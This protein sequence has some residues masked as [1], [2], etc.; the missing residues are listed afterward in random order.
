MWAMLRTQ[1][2]A[3]LLGEYEGGG[4]HVW[5]GP[6]A[7]IDEAKKRGTMQRGEKRGAR[8]KSLAFIGPDCTEKPVTPA[9][10]QGTKPR[11]HIKKTKRVIPSREVKTPGKISPVSSDE[12]TY[13]RGGKGA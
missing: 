11:D 6:R 1:E 12:K 3:T 5:N 9:Q 7:N 10:S 13:P 8:L 2:D 4:R